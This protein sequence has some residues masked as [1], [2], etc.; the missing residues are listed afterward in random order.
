MHSL[1]YRRT[2]GPRSASRNVLSSLSGGNLIRMSKTVTFQDPNSKTKVSDRQAQS[3]LVD[4]ILV[5]LL[6]DAVDTV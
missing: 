5:I 3:E 6:C 2:G 4:L 1:K